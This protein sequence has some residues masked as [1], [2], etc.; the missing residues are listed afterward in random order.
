MSMVIPRRSERKYEPYP[1]YKDSGAE[2]LGKVPMHWIVKRLKYSVNLI[3]D[4]VETGTID[5]PYI[6]LENV[7]SWTGRLVEYED[8][9]EPE[10]TS[11]RFQPKDILFSKLRP[12]LAKVVHAEQDGIC[13]SE[14][15]VLRPLK[16]CFPSFLFYYLLSRD[17][18]GIVNS[19]TYGVKMPRANWQ[20]IGNL[21]FPAI[22]MDEQQTIAVFLDRETTR[23]DD[24][25][26]KKKKLIE[27]LRKKRTALITRAV[28]RGLNPDAPMKGSG[29]EWLGEIPAHWEVK[30]L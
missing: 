19:A 14:L 28:T 5:L 11:N 23:I 1:E 30:K 26:E 27:L 10:S 17:T 20:F 6:G 24:L 13:S 18:I 16:K 7:E 9:I 2:W 4:K 29:V 22:E 8:K 3:N 12:Y 15:I 25:V 21:P